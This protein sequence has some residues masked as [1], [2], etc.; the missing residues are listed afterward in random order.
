MNQPIVIV[1]IGEFGSIFTKAFL[2]K[3]YPVYPVTRSMNISDQAD[4]IPQPELVL[5]A[6]A[7]NDFKAVMATIPAAWRHCTGLLQNELLP[8][9]WT[10]YDL[11]KPTI[12]SV[13][14]E[15]KK[16]REYKVLIPSRVH[17]PKAGLLAESLEGIEIPCKILSSEDE[18]L[19]ELVLKTCL[20]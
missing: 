7:E 16:G 11:S 15:K 12:I 19:Y 2:Q 20:C 9:D 18:L 13:W 17:G 8:R 14:F 3:G 1:G 10:A 5:V 6:V 4:S